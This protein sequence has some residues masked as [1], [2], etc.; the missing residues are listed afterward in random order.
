MEMGFKSITYNIVNFVQ[1]WKMLWAITNLFLYG[2]WFWMGKAGGTWGHEPRMKYTYV[3]KKTKNTSQCFT[4]RNTRGY[5]EVTVC[6]S[7]SLK[8][9]NVLQWKYNSAERIR[10]V[11][12]ESRGCGRREEPCHYNCL[13]WERWKLV[14]EYE[15]KRACVCKENQYDST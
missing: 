10:A 2:K 13:Q 14:F 1:I 9:E 8:L 3:I 5:S 15:F 12:W 6:L 4:K 7:A 11:M